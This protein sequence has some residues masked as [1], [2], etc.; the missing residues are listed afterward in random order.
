M[1]ARRKLA[2]FLVVLLVAS[3]YVWA[4]PGRRE[5]AS[6]QEET[7]ALTAPTCTEN[8]A[9]KGKEEPQSVLRK[10]GKSETAKLDEVC[11]LFEEQVED[12][13]EAETDIQRL[14]EENERLRKAN[15]EQADTIAYA[16]GKLDK[17]NSTK[18]FFNIRTVI[19]FEDKLPQ[20]GI[21]GDIGLMLKSGMTVS[22]GAD[23][24]IGDFKSPVSLDWNLDS[25]K[26]NL[27]VGWVF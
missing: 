16:N 1:C 7:Q 15:A 25:L 10:Q 27:G 2:I 18:G 22:A 6:R 11:D 12:Q 19:G 8:E 24:M 4:F 5:Q 20:W 21:G 14:R 23:Y 17:A 26:I 9:P 3:C 13:L